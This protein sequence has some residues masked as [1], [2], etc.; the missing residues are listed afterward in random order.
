MK[1]I[2]VNGAL[3]VISML[4]VFSVEAVWARLGLTAAAGLFCC[5]LGEQIVRDQEER[6]D[7]VLLRLQEMYGEQQDRLEDALC[8]MT[9]ILK[10]MTELAAAGEKKLEE[11]L[12]DFVRENGETAE[13]QTERVIQAMEKQT[14][15][16]SAMT[17]QVVQAVERLADSGAET[18]EQVLRA[19]ERLEEKAGAMTDRGVQAVERLTEKAE[20]MTDRA[21]QAMEQLTEKAEGMTDRT[22]Q[23]VEQLGEKAEGMTDRT[24]QAMEQQTGKES[25][26]AE[27][28]SQAL[29]QLAQKGEEISSLLKREERCCVSVSEQVQ[30]MEA[31]AE[32]TSKKMQAL[33]EDHYNKMSDLFGDQ[34]DDLSDSLETM[35]KEQLKFLREYGDRMNES[36]K[37]LNQAVESGITP[38]LDQNQELLRYVQEVQ[39]E[40]T[41]LDK[42]ELDFLSSVWE[43]R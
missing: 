4:A 35:K 8:D 5:L 25:D 10:G 6:K 38:V 31:L 23:A 29:T 22:V 7:Q 30:A 36:V 33:A 37:E 41:S 32:R 17:E 3:M 40:W 19:A 21:V 28:V 24:V 34:S 16:G 27:R 2:S 14:E 11:S 15:N 9:E 20:G 18:G 42:K 13:R 1:R 26:M 39:K 43:G 12:R